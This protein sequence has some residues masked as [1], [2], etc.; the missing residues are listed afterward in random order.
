MEQTEE[1]EDEE[2]VTN[3]RDES[4]MVTI[5]VAVALLI[6]IITFGCVLF[7]RSGVWGKNRL[8]NPVNHATEKPKGL[9]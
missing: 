5:S 6:I 3:I 8:H 2:E 4:V 1:R 9:I 7:M